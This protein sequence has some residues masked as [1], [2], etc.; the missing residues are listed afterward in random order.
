[1][2]ALVI[3]VPRER[4]PIH[5]TN[6]WHIVSSYISKHLVGAVQTVYED[7]KIEEYEWDDN[8]VPPVCGGCNKVIR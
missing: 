4:W 5:W 1:M 3:T 8:D 6:H 7:S 2:K